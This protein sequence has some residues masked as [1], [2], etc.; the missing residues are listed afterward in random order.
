MATQADIDVLSDKLSTTRPLSW[1][2]VD[3]PVV[4]IF[5]NNFTE[6]QDS[7]GQ[8]LNRNGCG[9]LL[10]LW[11]GMNEDTHELF[12]TLTIRIR[13]SPV[14]KK[15]RRQGRLMFMIVPANALQLQGT[16]VDYADLDN[17][18]SP[19][20]FDMPSDT[21]SG[22]CKLLHVSLNLG[23][24][25][26]DVIMPEYQCRSNVVPQAMVLLRKLKSL[27][28][29]SSFHLYTNQDESRQAAIQHVS[30]ILPDGHAMM[31]PSVDLKGFYPGGRSA[32]RNMW[33]EQGWL[34]AGDK[35]VA[36]GHYGIE[37]NQKKIQDTSEQQ[38][39]PPY[40][41][42]TVPSP[43]IASQRPD[44]VLSL[45]PVI[46]LEP[47]QGLPELPATAPPSTDIH[48]GLDGQ[49][50][51]AHKSASPSI[52]ID[53][54]C[55]HARRCS[56]S[57]PEASLSSGYTATF[58]SG[59]PTQSPIHRIRDAL[60]AK[61]VTAE[62]SC[63]SVQVAA[64]CIGDRAFHTDNASTRANTP[65]AIFNSFPGSATRKRLPSYSLEE[66]TSNI[67]KRQAVA[68]PSAQTLH[69]NSLRA[70]FSPTVADTISHHDA[71]TFHASTKE[72]DFSTQGNQL[73]QWLSHAWHHCPTA[74]YLFIAELL[75]YGAALSGNHSQ[76]DITTCHINC[77]LALLAHCT[78]QRLAEDFN[79]ASTDREVD[80]ETRALI[81]WL[82]VLRPGADMEMFSA[83][84]HL[85]VL[86]QQSLLVSRLG[87]EYDSLVAGFQRQ[88]AELVSQ[89]CIQ[90]GAAVLQNHSNDFIS[91][92][93]REKD[94]V[95]DM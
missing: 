15:T 8:P 64:S 80:A 23:P 78:K 26:S 61:A 71:N 35:T 45:P 16:V 2:I 60:A 92:M 3:C 30:N 4:A 33:V 77:T 55:S 22:E 40:E 19:S 90:H 46:A 1:I 24:H 41:P 83:L 74:H 37:R 89:V 58:L 28:E 72:D 6:H 36:D 18:L 7:L 10:R 93:L 25:I 88:K 50:A 70:D 81:R 27:S 31:T 5:K 9:D 42:N 11:V 67:A 54:V 59:F 68:Q 84:L 79:Y 44:E 13:V 73:S 53:Q 52:A 91:M 17:K 69:L 95:H 85:S 43:V 14:R 76:D 51:C 34:K 21:Q 48:V 57:T 39:P 29:A 86:S 87:G 20:L 65:S 62:S 94:C 47:Q 56:P 49:Y 75:S 66:V 82:Y 63:P 32:C 12:V 38:P